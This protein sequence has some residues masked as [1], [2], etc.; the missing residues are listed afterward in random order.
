VASKRAALVA[1]ATLCLG[2]VACGPEKLAAVKTSSS[3]KAPAWMARAPKDADALYFTGAKEGSSSLDEGKESAMAAARDQAAQ[4]IGVEISAEHNDVMSTDE[5]ENK[6]SDKIRS[7]AQAVIRSAELADVYYEKI[8]R[9]AGSGTI[10][11]Y[12]VWVLLKLPKAEIA[13][14]RARQ[15]DEA[16]QT[17]SSALAR[18]REAQGQ[19]KQGNLLAALVRYRDVIAQ[20]KPLAANIATGDKDLATSGRLRQ[21]AED[22]AAQVQSR[23]RRAVVIAPDWVAGSV[24]QALSAKGFSASSSPS[25]SE[26]AALAQARTD[27]MPWV[28]V[29][30]AIST[31]GGR[32]FSQV[33]ANASLDV[34]ALDVRSGAVVASS[35]KQAKGVGRTPEA[36]QQ[37]AASEA[38]VD[39]GNELA[40]ALVAKEN[41][42]L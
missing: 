20:M 27:G 4:Y 22:A 18:L 37:A 17:A 28:I 34:R 36:A 12:D 30:K 23:A 6:A 39:A 9:E 7:R 14:E 33:A 26:A 2:A 25:T 8:S 38:G 35:Q 40:A 24:M 19:E 41:T 32:V 5:A 31:P 1:V 15:D 11:R 42:G 21:V 3:P 13:R 10:D 16:K 29:V